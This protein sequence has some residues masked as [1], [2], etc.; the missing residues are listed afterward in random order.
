VS[1]ITLYPRDI[2]VTGHP[3]RHGVADLQI[4]I[5]TNDTVNTHVIM[6]A[7]LLLSLYR[8]IGHKLADLPI[9]LVTEDVSK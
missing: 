4:V 2:H 3:A 7:D 9:C 1:A 6:T 8:Q 5:D